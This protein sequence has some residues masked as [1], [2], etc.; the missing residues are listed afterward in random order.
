MT[1]ERAA[2]RGHGPRWPAVRA[3]LVRK[4]FPPCLARQARNVLGAEIVLIDHEDW[5]QAFREYSGLSDEEM[6]ELMRLIRE[7]GQ[8]ALLD[9]RASAVIERVKEGRWELSEERSDEGLD[10]RD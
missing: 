3:R 5:Y 7:H 10:E 9:L 8:N 1:R 4:S 6:P 2:A